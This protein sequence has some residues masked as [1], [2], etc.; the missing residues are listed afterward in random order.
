[1]GV[2]G[3]L[4]YWPCLFFM[5]I[6]SMIS[7]EE[8]EEILQNLIQKPATN[9]HKT[10]HIHAYEYWGQITKIVDADTLDLSISV[11]FD[12]T[13]QARIRL[14]GVNTPEIH[15]VKKDSTEYQAGLKATNLIKE[16]IKIGDWVEVIIRQNDKGKYG[17][18][19]GLVYIDGLCL[20]TLL[21]QH[22]YAHDYGS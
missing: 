17:R 5:V 4:S 18:W 8:A 10:A 15:G 2:F 22:G 9:A 20:N 13:Y 6:L 12:V 1:M 19:L 11:G 3:W 16:H 7:Y 14:L 21:I